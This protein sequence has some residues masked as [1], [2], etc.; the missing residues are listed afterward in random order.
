MVT[1][2]IPKG[3]HIEQKIGSTLKAQTQTKAICNHASKHIEPSE[4]YTHTH[5]TKRNTTYNE[6]PEQIP[7]QS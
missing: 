6:L 7:E 2:R 4:T 3:V 1:Q 5:T